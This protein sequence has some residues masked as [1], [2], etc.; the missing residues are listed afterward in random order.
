MW[1]SRLQFKMEIRFLF[2]ED[3]SDFWAFIL[4]ILS[5]GMLVR[6][7][8]HKI[9]NVHIYYNILGY[10]NMISQFCLLSLL[11]LTLCFPYICI[12]F[13]KIERNRSCFLCI[14]I[15]VLLRLEVWTVVCTTNKEYII[16]NFNNNSRENIK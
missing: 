15:F 3:F 14:I 1:I 6:V 7:Q 5:V 2:C 16:H 8:N 9:I 13:A 11:F 10:V 4:L 12:W